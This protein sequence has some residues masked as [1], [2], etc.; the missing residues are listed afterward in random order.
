MNKN[1]YMVMVNNIPY[2]IYPKS[3][4]FNEGHSEYT[5][6]AGSVGGGVTEPVWSENI[7]NAL[8]K[9]KFK[10]YNTDLTRAAIALWKKTPGACVVSGIAKTG[11]PVVLQLATMGN[12][13]DFKDDG[14]DIEF[15]GAQMSVPV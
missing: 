11:A 5:T 6:E 1:L 12:N 10:M 13:P 15:T 14:V 7:E 4:E 3:F 8:G 2:T 9:V